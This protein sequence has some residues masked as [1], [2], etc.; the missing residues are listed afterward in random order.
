MWVG[1][2]FSPGR[3]PGNAER[4]SYPHNPLPVSG[5]PSPVSPS[6]RAFSFSPHMRNIAVG[7]MSLLVLV[8]YARLRRAVSRGLVVPTRANRH[9]APTNACQAPMGWPW[10]RPDGKALGGFACGRT[11]LIRVLL[12]RQREEAEA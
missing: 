8:G 10:R 3:T 5:L 12:V 11:E 7:A 1:P 6:P 4:P 9:V 2:G